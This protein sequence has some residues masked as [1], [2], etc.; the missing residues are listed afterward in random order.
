[1]LEEA[2]G[3]LGDEPNPAYT[4]EAALVEAFGFP[5]VVVAGH[6]SNLKITTPADFVLAEALLA[7]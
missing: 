6:A 2:F 4:D 1:M 5:V 7:Q 3:R